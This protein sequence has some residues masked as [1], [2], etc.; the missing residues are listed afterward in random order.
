MSDAFGINH[1]LLVKMLYNTPSVF[2][3]N[4]EDEVAEKTARLLT[5]LGLDVSCQDVNDPLPQR[6]E[7]VDVAVYVTNPLD[8]TKVAGQLAAFIGC[9]ESEA[10][11]LLLNEPSVV[12]GGVSIATAKSLQSRLSA[13]VIASNPRTDLYTIEMV[14]TD[15]LVVS[16]V[17]GTLRNM[18]IQHDIR[19]GRMI[20]GLTY[21]KAQELWNKYHNIA[22]LHIYNQSYKRYQVQLSHF[23]LQNEEQTAFLTQQVGIPAEALEDIH[24]NLPVLL[25]ESLNAQEMLARLEAYTNAG[26]RCEALAIPFGKYKITIHNISDS[27]RVQEI[28]SPFY[29]GTVLP[30]NT[31][32]WTAPLPLN[33]VLN[34]YLEKQLELMG[35]EVEH[36]YSEA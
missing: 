8:L 12:L 19:Q 26:L 2:L 24:A 16:Q 28:V 29:K 6:S 27:K 9:K 3:A 22:Q 34:R 21:E 30:E 13:E 10:L 11:Q 18:G 15:T 25:D 36:Q 32:E 17:L 14:T 4:A 5:Q 31:K 7:P 23:D 35:C 33:S 20:S 1:E